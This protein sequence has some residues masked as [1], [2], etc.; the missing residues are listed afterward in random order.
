MLKKLLA[1]CVFQL[2][3]LPALASEET[4][5]KKQS[6]IQQIEKLKEHIPVPELQ[7]IIVEYIGNEYGPTVLDEIEK[8]TAAAQSQNGTYLIRVGDTHKKD[9]AKIWKYENG[10]YTLT[11]DMIVPFEV[12]RVAIS[13][14]GKYIA[15]G[16]DGYEYSDIH[17]WRLKDNGSSY[18]EAL[19]EKNLP[20][21]STYLD[22]FGNSQFLG[23]ISINNSIEL[24]ELSDKWRK[25]IPVEIPEKQPGHRYGV[26][27]LDGTY[28]AA[29]LNQRFAVELW[30]FLNNKITFIN[31]FDLPSNSTTSSIAFSPSGKYIALGN[32]A[33]VTK[34]V[35]YPELVEIVSIKNNRLEPIQTIEAHI[36]TQNMKGI[37]QRSKEAQSIKFS[38]D[39][40]YLAI[41]SLIN[42]PM[43]HNEI[44][45]LKFNSKTKKYEKIATLPSYFK[46]IGFSPN[47]SIITVNPVSELT[48]WE[49]QKEQLEQDVGEKIQSAHAQEQAA[50]TEVD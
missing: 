25:L 42:Y 9:N 20:D 38:H 29:A 5:A 44:I 12:S 22:F 8:I 48:V 32:R 40:S 30:Q 10:T 31:T 46:L 33:V 35:N 45:V 28:I 3:T 49:N 4:I 7:K 43:L 37:E 34:T 39:G 26:V 47:N 2:L 6:T 16:T 15:F 36:D 19:I 24:W 21:L 1:L 23:R 14:D 41:E 13:N 17:I 50:I 11:H 27:S 18:T